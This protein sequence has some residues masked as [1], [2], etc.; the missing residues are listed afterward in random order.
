[1]FSRDAICEDVNAL[2][3]DA[4]N[5][6]D[7]DLYVVSAGN[8]SGG[9]DSALLDRLY[10]NDGKGNFVKS[11]SL[12]P[13]YENKSVAVEADF[14]RDGDLD[15]FVGG[16]VVAGRYGEIPSSYL[17]INKGKAKFVIATDSICPGLRN[18]GMVTGAVWSDVDQD[19]W[20]DLAM[21]GEWM[22]VTIFRNQK[23]KLSRDTLGAGLENTSGLWCSLQKADINNDGFDDLMVRKLWIKFKASCQ[24]TVPVAV[25]Y[26]RP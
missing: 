14:D 12:P 13:I 5:D 21:A 16:R 6:G 4:D 11:G 3:F 18:I 24:S 22:P 17:L 10:I 23:G 9:R 15:L 8:E 19:G 25:I 26:R 7:K 1:L 20:P 2:F